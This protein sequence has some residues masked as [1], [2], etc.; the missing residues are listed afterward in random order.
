[1]TESNP[2]I[3]VLLQE[4]RKFPPPPGFQKS[5]WV[6]DESI[7]GK[8]ARDPEAFWAGWAKELEWIKPWK[9][10]LEWNPPRAKWFVD[11]KINVCVNCVDRHV[12]AASGSKDRRNK[13]ALIW[14][15]EP[16]DTRTLTYGDLYREVNQFAGVLR[17]LG[18]QKA[19]ASPFISP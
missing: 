15:G 7:Y 14:E 1:M 9:K 3:S 2:S 17:K 16:G 8:A 4:S 6:K 19:T 10:V 13:A 5:A 11:G 18:I 12:N